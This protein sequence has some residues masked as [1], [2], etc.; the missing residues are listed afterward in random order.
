MTSTRRVLV[1]MPADRWLSSQQNALKWSIVRRIEAIGYKA[2]IFFDPRGQGGLA[3]AEAW[4]PLRVD[5][6]ARRCVGAAVIGLPR[7]VVRD[8]HS[9]L[10]L[11]TEFNHYEGAVAYT[12][13]I[14]M[15]VLAQ[16]D[17][18]R[19]VVFDDHF[20]SYVGVFSP[21]ADP[22]WLRTRTF[23][24]PF[25]SWRKRL[26]QR[27]DVFLGYCGSS[28]ATASKLKRF[29]KLDL[30]A[31][32][33]DWK[34]DFKPGQTILQQIEQAAQRCSSGIFLFTADDALS[35]GSALAKA[36]PRDN[37]V[38]EAGYF[39]N[40]KG[41]DRVLIVLE[42]SAKMPADLG[43]DIYASLKSKKDITPIKQ[44]VRRFMNNL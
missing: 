25:Q 17:I 35:E 43:G 38:F 29:L 20:D 6:V 10:K 24:V 22:S 5:A 16:E 23:R 11:P 21:Q 32:V 42:T 31:T 14:P 44:T 4:T 26:S 37:V 3:A 9:R 1:S 12:L 28:I 7:W 36:A 2:E 39:I 41:K 8:G 19:R 15:L 27:R 18:M 34:T 30:G 33:L 13:R 40:A